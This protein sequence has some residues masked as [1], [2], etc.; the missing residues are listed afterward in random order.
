MIAAF[1]PA[2]SVLLVCLTALVGW[3]MWLSFRREQVADSF[4]AIR[5]SLAEPRA[6]A[7]QTRATVDAHSS[8]LEEQGARLRKLQNQTA[9]RDRA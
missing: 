3:R 7:E 9:M 8:S 5:D 6:L 1:A 2:A 4:G